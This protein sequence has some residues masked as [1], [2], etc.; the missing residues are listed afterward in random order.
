MPRSLFS[1]I[2]NSIKLCNKETGITIVEPN[3]FKFICEGKGSFGCF[4]GMT[5]VLKRFF[6]D[7]IKSYK[8]TYNNDIQMTDTDVIE[9]LEYLHRENIYIKV[10]DREYVYMKE[11]VS[12]TKFI[13]FFGKDLVDS[14]TTFASYKNR[15]GFYIKFNSNVNIVL[16]GKTLSEFGMII[17]NK[18]GTDLL[19]I[20]PSEFDYKKLLDN[21]YPIML[22]LHKNNKYHGDIKLGNIV[23]NSNSLN[24]IKYKLIDYDFRG[25]NRTPYYVLPFYLATEPRLL[26]L[27]TDQLNI[28]SQ[29]NSSKTHSELN[30]FNL[31]YEIF[32][33]FFT[34]ITQVDKLLQKFNIKD[35]ETYIDIK[36]DEYALAIVL[37]NNYESSKLLT[38]EYKDVYKTIQELLS[39]TPYFLNKH[40]N[41]TI[42]QF[43]KRT[44]KS[45]SFGG[46]VKELETNIKTNVKTNRNK[47]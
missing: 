25:T 45:N 23:Y 27:Y 17:Y 2:R 24:D 11:N 36:C 6:I 21:I 32:D 10:F 14:F 5:D 9:L 38:P 44:R 40:N 31:S 26:D 12:N 46:K 47:K 33:K 8:M 13:K 37:F 22:K 29:M 15:S 42:A 41:E 30:L 34:D 16:H 35:Y 28:W 7:N 20:S 18:F 39:V 19:Q 43:F 4:L 1:K 3:C